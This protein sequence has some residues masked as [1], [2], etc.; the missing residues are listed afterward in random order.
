[1]SDAALTGLVKG[2]LVAPH[3]R[4]AL[5]V[6][7]NIVGRD[8][9]SDVWLDEVDVSRRHA[10]II[11]SGDSAAIEDLGGKNGTVVGVTPVSE[12]A[13][14]NDGDCIRFGCVSLTY[15]RQVT[16]G[17]TVTLSVHATPEGR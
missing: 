2:G 4:H 7:I 1:M 11:I 16:E 15:R 10:R 3:R 9:A 14:L 5:K 13:K 6:G 8:A 17:S 12:P